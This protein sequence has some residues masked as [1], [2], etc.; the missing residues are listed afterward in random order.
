V[1]ARFDRGVGRRLHLRDDTRPAGLFVAARCDDS[2][3]PRKARGN[4]AIA[5][6]LI[7][8]KLPPKGKV[9]EQ[10]AAPL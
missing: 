1:P 10:D 8:G 5:A 7:G 3:R 2:A 9:C 4:G 6:Y